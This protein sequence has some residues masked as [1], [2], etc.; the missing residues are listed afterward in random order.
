VSYHVESRYTK[1]SRVY[2]LKSVSAL[3]F[4]ELILWTEIPST[5]GLSLE[6]AQRFKQGYEERDGGHREYRVVPD[7]AATPDS[8][9]PGRPR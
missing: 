8:A 5:M 1:R 2:Q 3:E 9:E 6:E 7:P 4:A